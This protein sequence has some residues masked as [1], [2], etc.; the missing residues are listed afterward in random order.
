[1][2]LIFSRVRDRYRNRG[3]QDGDSNLRLASTE[4]E[5]ALTTSTRGV[6]LCSAISSMRFD[7]YTTGSCPLLGIEVNEAFKIII[8]FPAIQCS[9]QHFTLMKGIGTT[10]T[11]SMSIQMNVY[12]FQTCATNCFSNYISSDS[13]LNCYS[14]KYSK[15]TPVGYRMGYILIFNPIQLTISDVALLVMPRVHQ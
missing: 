8:Q 14:C 6:V 10:G 3:W 12:S 4:L 1:M 9:Y 11:K 13:F 15:K 5:C 7:H 2:S